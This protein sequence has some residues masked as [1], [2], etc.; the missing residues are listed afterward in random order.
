MRC[1][2]RPDGALNPVG[3]GGVLDINWVILDDIRA[4]LTGCAPNCNLETLW[5]LSHQSNKS[6]HIVS[7][8]RP[9]HL[10]E[11]STSSGTGLNP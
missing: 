5:G 4:G 10:I 6:G 8:L 11:L 9:S 3:K 1:V 7:G 2:W